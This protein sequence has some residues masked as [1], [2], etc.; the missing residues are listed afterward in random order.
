MCK[1]V[2]VEDTSS[3]EHILMMNTF[4]RLNLAALGLASLVA[5]GGARDD[6]GRDSAAATFADSQ[7]GMNSPSDT[8]LL[9]NDSTM[10]RDT[11]SSLSMPIDKPNRGAGSGGQRRP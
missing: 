5:C 3:L 9:R 6:A 7:P 2:R 4:A 8:A 10:R 11:M 1:S